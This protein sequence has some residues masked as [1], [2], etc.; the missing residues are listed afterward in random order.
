[1]NVANYALPSKLF[2]AMSVGRPFVCIAEIDSPLD[3]LTRQ[4]GAGL[5][6]SPQDEEKFFEAVVS[7]AENFEDQRIKGRNG[8]Q[9][10]STHMS[11]EIIM[12]EY[13][14]VLL[15]CGSIGVN[16]P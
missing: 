11:K 7:L 12:E 4:S 14:K 3:M 5:C 15:G 9:F 2:S 6:V 13:H 16:V 8:R 10:V 1:L